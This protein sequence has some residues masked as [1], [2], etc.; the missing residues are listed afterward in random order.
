MVRS[1]SKDEE[2]FFA[3]FRLKQ[4]SVYVTID[5]DKTITFHTNV[6]SKTRQ[7]DIQETF[8]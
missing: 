5:L 2:H 6:N 7:T 3:Q 4:E 8:R 1:E